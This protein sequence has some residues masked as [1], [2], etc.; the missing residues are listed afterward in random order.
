MIEA[1]RR[2]KRLRQPLRTEPPSVA[3]RMRAIIARAYVQR[4]HPDG[5]VPVYRSGPGAARAKD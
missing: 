3:A 5:P 4:R 2:F 1:S